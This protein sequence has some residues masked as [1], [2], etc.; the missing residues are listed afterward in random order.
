MEERRVLSWTHVYGHSGDHGNELA[1]RL[2]DR[3]ARG[4]VGVDSRRWANGVETA[5]T[6]MLRDM[7]VCPK[8]GESFPSAAL[9]AHKNRCQRPEA[10]WVYPRGQLPC[11]KCRK[12]VPT[13]ERARHEKFCRG[14]EIANKT[15]IKCGRFFPDAEV[16]TRGLPLSLRNHERSCTGAAG[17]AAPGG[18]AGAGGGDAD[19]TAVA[20]LPE[21]GAAAEAEGPPLV[22]RRP[23]AAPVRRQGPVSRRPAGHIAAPAPKRA[24]HR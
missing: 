4:E 13:T 3:G 16:G 5:V 17:S 1:D 9:R 8:C 12:G 7:D 19:G 15:C 10:E 21:A 2:A 11:R 18:A 23:A 14:S 20:A 22:R 24:R 6:D